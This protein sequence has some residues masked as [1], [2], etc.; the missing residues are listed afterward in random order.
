MV[1]NVKIISKKFQKTIDKKWKKQYNE[2]IIEKEEFNMEKFEAK[3]TNINQV[4]REELE[5]ICTVKC[6]S[7][8]VN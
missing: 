5:E 6:M 1:N 8:D 2:I 4:L 7:C 3:E